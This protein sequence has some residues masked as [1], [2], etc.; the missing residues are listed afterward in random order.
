MI[1]SDAV[2]V[3][4][5]QNRG[6]RG[7]ITA[8]PLVL[9]LPLCAAVALLRFD[10]NME[11][12]W[13][14]SV[15]TMLIHAFR[16]GLGKVLIS[17]PNMTVETLHPF[18]LPAMLTPVALTWEN[19]VA[20]KLALVGIYLLGTVVIYR[21]FST[22]FGVRIGLFVT[23]CYALNVYTIAYAYQINAEIVYIPLSVLA[24]ISLLRY[25]RS[26][27]IVGWEVL[28]AAVMLNA[29]IYMR[30]VGL[31]LL[32]AGALWLL[33]QG[34]W[35]KAVIMPLTTL[36]ISLPLQLGWVLGSPAAWTG[37]YVSYIGINNVGIIEQI[38][39]NLVG[40]TFN[41]VR[42]IIELPYQALYN[43]S[44]PTDG[45]V[46]LPLLALMLVLP[47]G[48]LALGMLRERTPAGRLLALYTVI[49]MGVLLIW[50]FA[51][52]PHFVLPILPM[53]LFFL[54]RGLNG[55][56]KA[57]RKA[58]SATVLALMVLV[59][60]FSLIQHIDDGLIGGNNL[61]KNVAEFGLPAHYPPSRKTYMEAG[62]WLAAHSRADAVILCN[63]PYDFYLWSGRHTLRYYPTLNTDGQLRNSDYVVANSGD[64][65]SAT[66]LGNYAAAHPERLQLLYKVEGIAPASVYLVIK[67][68]ADDYEQGER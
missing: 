4:S 66:P 47:L 34:S 19:P 1:A 22:N 63:D 12:T 58:E 54:V 60:G 51:P 41:V 48:L 42:L 65:G 24:C 20:Y 43:S 67:L 9:L 57:W 27:R 25:Q 35:R 15:Y 40:Y 29:S 56:L 14:D 28:F 26:A 45:P 36:L 38:S 16:N 68:E 21:F 31:A 23:I 32:V 44:L 53:L 59:A 39:Q 8:H 18:G 64:D 55:T 33:W 50:P 49:Y 3:A 5:E 52:H 10:P 62:Q 11:Y 46:F 6:M 37:G 17:D 30:S 7:F 61:T 2:A 13:D